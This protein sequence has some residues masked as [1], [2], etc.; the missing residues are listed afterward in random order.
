[1]GN[2]SDTGS[3]SPMQNMRFARRWVRD[4]EYAQSVRAHK[5]FAEL[6]RLFSPVRVPHIVVR[7]EDVLFRPSVTVDRICACVGGYRRSDGTVLDEGASKPHGKSRTR[8]QALDSY[9]DTE[10]R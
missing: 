9:A 6:Q 3:I 5:E 7:F 8:Q 2:V 1:M 4:A 10:Q